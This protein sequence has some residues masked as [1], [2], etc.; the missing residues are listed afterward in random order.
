MSTN[1][2]W[3]AKTVLGEHITT[4]GPESHIGKRSGA[5]EGKCIFTW[6]QDS[7][8]V[9]E[10]CKNNL[11]ARIIIDEY[12]AEYTGHEFLELISDYA[13]DYTCINQRFS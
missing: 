4:D 3:A 12:N 7:G 8:R 6:A 10:A 1:F 9:K 2:Y 5:G 13:Q 11:G